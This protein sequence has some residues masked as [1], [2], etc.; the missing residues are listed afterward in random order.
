MIKKRLL[1][2]GMAATLT[3]CNS[4]QAQQPLLNQEIPMDTETT[5]EITNL[6]EETKEEDISTEMET[7]TET[8]TSEVLDET[9]SNEEMNSIIA[10]EIPTEQNEPDLLTTDGSNSFVRRADYVAG[11]GTPGVATNTVDTAINSSG[12]FTKGY[13]QLTASNDNTT[14]T[15]EYLTPGNHSSAYTMDHAYVLYRYSAGNVEVL[16]M[17]CYKNTKKNQW[18]TRGYTLASE[19]CNALGEETFEFATNLPIF[20]TYYANYDSSNYPSALNYEAHKTE[21]VNPYTIINVHDKMD[22]DTIIGT[23]QFV[24]GKSLSCGSSSTSFDTAF[25]NIMKEDGFISWKQKT[26]AGY[27]TWFNDSDKENIQICPTVSYGNTIELYPSTRESSASKE[28]MYDTPGK[29]MTNSNLKSGDAICTYTD[30]N[31][32]VHTKTLHA[33]FKPTSTNGK[34]V[35]DEDSKDAIQ[36]YEG[37]CFVRSEKNGTYNYDLYQFTY[38]TAAKPELECT[39][40]LDNQT[41]ETT[42]ISTSTNYKKIAYL[43]GV[44][45][46]DPNT[47]FKTN[48]PIYDTLHNAIESVSLVQEGSTNWK[49]HD[50]YM[51]RAINYNELAAFIPNCYTKFVYH[52]LNGDEISNAYEMC[53]LGT[54]GNYTKNHIKSALNTYP[55]SKNMIT[56]SKYQI[57]RWKDKNGNPFPDDNYYFPNGYYSDQWSVPI[58]YGN[59]V[60]DL[61]PEVVFGKGTTTINYNYTLPDGTIVQT[62]KSVYDL[63]DSQGIPKYNSLSTSKQKF[64]VKYKVPSS[65]YKLMV[66]NARDITT[67]ISKKTYPNGTTEREE[68][69]ISPTGTISTSKKTVEFQY[70]PGVTFLANCWKE[71]NYKPLEATIDVSIP[72]DYNRYQLTLTSS[73]EE[74]TVVI[75]T[76]YYMNENAEYNIGDFGQKNP[77]KKLIGFS[78]SYGNMIYTVTENGDLL[79]TD[80][81]TMYWKKQDD[82]YIYRFFSDTLQA[83]YE[84]K[85]N[86]HLDANGGHCTISDI[87]DNPGTDVTLPNTTNEIYKDGYSFAGWE[88]INGTIYTDI[89]T[90]PDQDITLKAKWIENTYK[91][92]LD[93]MQGNVWTGTEAI[94]K[95]SNYTFLDNITNPN[96]TGYTFTGW[97]TEKVEG[98]KVTAQSIFQETKD[99]T[100]YAHYE[101]NH[102]NITFINTITQDVIQKEVTYDQSWGVIPSTSA[103]NKTFNGWIDDNGNPFS[104]TSD[105]IVNITSNQTYYS[106]FIDKPKSDS[107]EPK[108]PEMLIPPV[109]TEITTETTTE[110]S[111][112][113]TTETT[114]ETN[115]QTTSHVVKTGDKSPIDALICILLIACYSCFL[116]YEQ[117]HDKT[118]NKKRINDIEEEE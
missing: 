110:I 81:D 4:V 70:M 92:L 21:W 106:D 43:E 45:Y 94:T 68:A 74:G 99:Q 57:I 48:L 77:R 105:D 100:L 75:P 28:Q 113:V 42:N 31:G 108:A 30:S 107:E 50:N 60:I 116:I 82:T 118:P 8:E 11:E 55:T 103:E 69:F 35:I 91:V 89:I 19:V 27:Q 101:A 6:S 34:D 84:T 24:P 33:S 78:N 17:E 44:D 14:I 23:Y 49:N 112:E 59:E 38:W 95:S 71:N 46:S 2:I 13:L 39:I 3:L 87:T 51:K 72:V 20:T 15:S 37:L 22:S 9:V 36:G 115:S 18:T 40:Q 76:I 97:F 66:K 54:A 111:T 5:S 102:Y 88:D 53:Y 58:T 7:A 63:F 47:T 41:Q 67:K 93:D 56:N 117:K 85:S 96:K 114:T 109:S 52:D 32:T 1:A 65:S 86:I 61:Y 26:D 73:E 104:F 80:S 29:Y 98:E 12:G 16:L 90:I 62:D 10:E 79:H 83:V 64:T 25:E